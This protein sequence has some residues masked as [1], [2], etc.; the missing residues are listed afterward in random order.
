MKKNRM[1]ERAAHVV[2][3]MEVNGPREFIEQY[4]NSN[5]I[6]SITIRFGRPIC[7]VHTHGYHEHGQRLGVHPWNAK[8]RPMNTH[9]NF[10]RHI[11]AIS[12]SITP[13]DRYLS[14]TCIDL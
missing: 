13:M 2:E 6:G 1:K 10:K 12:S 7:Q 14:S 11:W 5:N 4:W 9:M 3:K 8:A